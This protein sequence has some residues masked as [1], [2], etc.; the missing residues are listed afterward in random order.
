ML[1]ISVSGFLVSVRNWYIKD[2]SYGSKREMPCLSCGA[3]KG[4]PTILLILEFANILLDYIFQ[5]T[6]IYAVD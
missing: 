1:I 3:A 4:V 2:R 6:F 5:C